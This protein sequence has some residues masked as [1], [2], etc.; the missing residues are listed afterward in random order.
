MT[1]RGHT[2]CIIPSEGGERPPRKWRSTKLDTVTDFPVT[3]FQNCTLS[4]ISLDTVTD[5]QNWT[6]SPISR[7]LRCVGNSPGPS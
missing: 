4:P 7:S 5:F 6:L 3:D 2:V 1:D